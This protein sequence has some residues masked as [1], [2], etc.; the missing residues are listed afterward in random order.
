[1]SDEAI[2][3][4]VDH[5][6]VESLIPE[7]PVLESALKSNHAAG[8]PEI[9][10]SPAFGA[11]LNLLVRISGARKILEI[12]TLGGY[13]TIWMARAVGKGGRLFSLELDEKHAEVA[14]ANI[15]RAGLGDVVE[16]RAGKALDLLPALQSEAPFD[17]V[18]IDADKWSNRS[19]IDWAVRLGRP[20]TIVI[21]DNVVRD[22]QVIQGNSGDPS[23]RGAR[24][25]FAALGD[26]RFAG[27]ALQSVGAKGYD[28]F[29]IA[30]IK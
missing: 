2:W 15:A 14:R 27:T 16:V 9:D 23:V 13:S 17:L 25:A 12:G 29:A 18:F 30:T 11:L 3:K 24:A 20:G 8:L 22:G 6:I 21:V 1:M 19:Y 10:V 28:G 7:D 26:G 5:Y 4:A